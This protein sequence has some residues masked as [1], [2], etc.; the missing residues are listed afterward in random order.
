MIYDVLVVGGGPAGLTA[1]IYARRSG[2]S[3][4]VLERMGYGGQIATSPR[5]ENY[6]GVADV[7]GVAL[8]EQMLNQALA[9]ETETDVGSVTALRRENGLWLADTEEGE[10]FTARTV[11]LAVGAA[12]RKLGVAGE[13]ELTGRGVS[14]CAVC[15]GAF[16]AGKDVAVVGG[17]DSALQEALLLSERCRK[18]TLIHRRD[19]LR[20]GELLQQRLFARPNVEKLTPY[21]IKALR[22][23]DGALTGV[24]A[25]RADGGEHRVLEL[26]GLFVACGQLPATAPFAALLPLDS[27]GYALLGED[28]TA[29][30]GLFVAG[31]C[32]KKDVRQLT[33]AVSDGSCAALAAVKYLE[34]EV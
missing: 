26:S 27:V 17:G 13:E 16:F 15:D 25:E 4:L 22:S 33:T 10:R 28:C 6:P 23:A 5:V 19:E 20:G 18:V 2:K 29:G 3:V 30:D 1:A 8:S 32:R 34:G 14:Y 9:L 24:E 21:N 31:D 12:H 11:I 7:S